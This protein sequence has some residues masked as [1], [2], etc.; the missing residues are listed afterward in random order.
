MRSEEWFSDRYR[1]MPIAPTDKSH[2]G[3]PGDVFLRQIAFGPNKPP[4]SNP[5]AA[6]V[7]DCPY[8][9][10]RLAEL[11]VEPARA[12]FPLIPVAVFATAVL[13]IVLAIG[14]RLKTG[15]GAHEE[16]AANQTLDLSS[17]SATRGA[18]PSQEPIIRLPRRQ[19]ELTILLPL[20]SDDGQYSV[21]ILS[22]RTRPGA[23]AVAQ[24]T[25][26]QTGKTATLKVA[27]DLSKVEQGI[28]YLA[29]IHGADK[30]TYYYPIAIRDRAR[31]I[32]S[33]RP[34][35]RSRQLNGIATS[36]GMGVPS[37]TLPDHVWYEPVGRARR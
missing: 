26:I 6:H 18:A 10:Q 13:L 37:S 22:D 19:D 3:G 14:W 1:K 11:R 35:L 21:E 2:I 24:G 5:R 36:G 25:A 12:N 30:A 32:C 27:F 8:C 34:F 31:S 20:F 23:V 17:V 33:S 16:E 4:L 7:A 9:L 28:Y 29:T 15:S